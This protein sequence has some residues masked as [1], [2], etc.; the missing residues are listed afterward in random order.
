MP[1][2][3]KERILNYIPEEMR[4]KIATEEDAKTLDEL[5]EFLR[6]VD[7]PVVKGV[8]RDVDG[9]KI[10]DGWVEEIEE[11]EEAAPEE[12]PAEAPAAPAAQ[13]A[14]QPMPQMQM[15]SFQLPALQIPAPQTAPA[16]IKLIIKDAKITIDKVIIRKAEKEKKGGK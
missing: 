9:Q 7:H 12:V 11:V 4:D 10:T 1:K 6:K 16:G 13:P 2:D 15:P 14:V 8:V 3:L 5:K